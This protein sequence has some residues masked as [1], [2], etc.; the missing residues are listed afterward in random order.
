[1]EN[2]PAQAASEPSTLILFLVG[3]S[4]AKLP[5][6]R[7]APEPYRRARRQTQRAEEI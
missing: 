6:V 3:L 2:H 4:V 7:I 1:M 5:H